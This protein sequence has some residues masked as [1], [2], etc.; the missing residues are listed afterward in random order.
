MR[1]AAFD[2]AYQAFNRRAYRGRHF[3]YRTDCEP[4]EIEICKLRVS[5][6]GRRRRISRGS[7]SSLARNSSR[8]ATDGKEYIL[9]AVRVVRGLCRSKVEF[10]RGAFDQGQRLEVVDQLFKIWNWELSD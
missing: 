4:L 2:F 9:S 5:A 1:F 7:P 10:T 6:A 3:F 8:Q